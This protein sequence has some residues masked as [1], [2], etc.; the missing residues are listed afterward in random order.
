MM[1]GAAGD[2]ADLIGETEA[3]AVDPALA[4]ST[5]DRLLSPTGVGHGRVQQAVRQLHCFCLPLLR[6]YC[7]SRL[8]ERPVT[9]GAGGALLPSDCR[10]SSSQQGNV[11]RVQGALPELGATLRLQPPRPDRLARNAPPQ[12]S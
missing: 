6:P 9:T 4:G 5:L 10:G 3:L 1:G 8:S 12:L 11:E 7:H 2:I